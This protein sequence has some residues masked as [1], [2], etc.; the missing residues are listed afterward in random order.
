MWNG[1]TAIFSQKYI[2]KHSWLQKPGGVRGGGVHV[3]IV[4]TLYFK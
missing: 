2:A 1:K 4:K 3:I